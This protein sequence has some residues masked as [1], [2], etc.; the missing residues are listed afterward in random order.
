MILGMINY[1]YLITRWFYQDVWRVIVSIASLTNSK[2]LWLSILVPNSSKNENL[3]N[4][5]YLKNYAE[6]LSD[7]SEFLNAYWFLFDL[8]QYV[9]PLDY[10]TPLVAPQRGLFHK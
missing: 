4:K 5:V 8:D 10:K 2:E 1:Y 3:T 7:R 9:S 6:K